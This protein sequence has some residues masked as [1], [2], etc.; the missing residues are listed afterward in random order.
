MA[1]WHTGK[2][3]EHKHWSENLHTLYVDAEIEPFEAGQFVKIGLEINGEVIAHPY[4]LVNPPNQTPLSFYYI[5]VPDGKLTSRLSELKTNDSVLVAPK[6]HGFLIL[7]EIPAAKHLWLMATGTGIGPF[8]S[9]LGTAK[10]WQRYEKIVLVWA[11][12][13]FAELTYQDLIHQLLTEH[14]LQ[15]ICIPFVSREITTSA[16]TGRI[17]QAI[18][19]GRLEERAGISI[20][21]DDSQVMLCGNPQMVK[22]TTNTLIERGLKKHRRFSPGHISSE[23]YW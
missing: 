5:N 8:L 15:F 17:P 4:S 1:I 14:P 18:I 22:D 7:D 16:L 20:H 9:M 2:V 3:V 10:P 23:N 19:D 12:R 13:T 11:T 21:T 6:A